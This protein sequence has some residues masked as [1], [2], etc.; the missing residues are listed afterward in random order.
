MV[1]DKNKMLEPVYVVQGDSGRRLKLIVS[2]L[3]MSKV[4]ARIYVWKPDGTEV[5]SDCIV[6][7]NIVVANLTTQMLAVVGQ[8]KYQIQLLKEND[9][10]TSF[11]GILR[12]ED[13]LV[14]DSALESSNEFTALE[15]ALQD[16]EYLKEHG[17]K[18]DRGEKGD[19]GEKGDKG[20]KGDPGNIDNIETTMVN[21]SQAPSRINIV[22]GEMVTTLFGKIKK[23]FA[24]LKDGAFMTVAN[25]L[26]A[27]DSGSVLDARQGK[28]LDG[29]I[30]EVST[31][32]GI[33]GIESSGTGYVRFK[34]GTQICYGTASAGPYLGVMPTISLPVPYK[35]MEYIVN[36]GTRRN[37]NIVTDM[38]VGDSAGN[39][40][41]TTS[42]FNLYIKKSS[43]TNSTHY[44]HTI[45]RWK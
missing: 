33:G 11:I 16:V 30:I 28:V 25:N 36:Y 6:E 38:W 44:W 1:S 32:L 10:V 45:G 40:Q 20:D 2:D 41:N 18:G 13:N 43:A 4:A 19:Q 35:D 5:Y 8:V 21:F 29:K 15:T 34:D 42:S 27:A 9:I 26:I 17:L 7:D 37:G 22:S 24:D 31:N 12:V 39:N 3:E 14:D 23:Y